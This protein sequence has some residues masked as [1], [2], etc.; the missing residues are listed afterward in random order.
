MPTVHRAPKITIG[1]TL[2]T[3]GV[4]LLVASWFVFRFCEFIY[5]DGYHTQQQMYAP[6]SPRTWRDTFDYGIGF[7]LWSLPAVA[8]AVPG[9]I[10]AV[11]G[12][13]MISPQRP[14]APGDHN[15]SLDK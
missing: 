14:D 1:V 6:D 5:T 15:P 7:L 4:A 10:A 2:A 9:L 3:L 8:L 13:R 11:C 12:C